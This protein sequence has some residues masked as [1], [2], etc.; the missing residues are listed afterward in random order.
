ML[1]YLLFY[2]FQLL[3]GGVLGAACA[4]LGV[5]VLLQRQT[6][7]AATLSQAGVLAFACVVIAT[8]LF[9]SHGHGHSEAKVSIWFV[10]A[11]N[12]LLMAPFYFLRRRRIVNL[13][14]A[15]VAGIAFF[16]AAAQVLTVVCG[17]HTHLLT[18]YFGNILTV[19]SRDLIS[20]SIVLVP[21]IAAFIVMY[22]SLA[23]TTF[24]R[25][26]ARLAGISTAMV[27]LAFFILLGAV[28]ALTLRLMG[29]FYTL[30]HLVVPGLFALSLTRS[31][32]A[33]V[34][35][36]GCYSL[37][38]TIGGFTLSLVPITIA[39]QTINLPTSSVIVLVL[40][41]GCSVLF[42]RRRGR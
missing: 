12:I 30:G 27:D 40:V 19:S 10:L 42:F 18:A 4:I 35:V 41:V 32:G 15:L 21:G 20:S 24:D 39:D 2:K 26:Q 8:E 34:L 31:L 9:D 5:F 22:R 11:L 37:A 29:S 25:D 28:A 36:A 13:D 17:L 14:A 23:A 33:S 1:E 16:S 7:F 6:L 3:V 38:A